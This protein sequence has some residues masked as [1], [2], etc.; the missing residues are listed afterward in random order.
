LRREAGNTAFCAASLSHCQEH[1]TLPG[2]AIVAFVPIGRRSTLD[3]PRGEYGATLR[4][5]RGLRLRR[6][7]AASDACSHNTNPGLSG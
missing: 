6:F 4:P 7:S 5:N 3:A 1:N 2:S